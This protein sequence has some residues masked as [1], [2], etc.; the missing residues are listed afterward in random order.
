MKSG[1]VHVVEVDTT[2]VGSDGGLLL[3]GRHVDLICEDV[4]DEGS[5]DGEVESD[6]QLAEGLSVAANEHGQAVGSVR[7]GCDAAYR[8]DDADGDVTVVDQVCDVRKGRWI[9]GDPLT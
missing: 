8:F 1:C 6:H 4:V 7:G 5:C 3:S 9:E 2:C